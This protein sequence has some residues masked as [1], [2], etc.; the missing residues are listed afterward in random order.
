MS[1]C[2]D[3]SAM[4]AANVAPEGHVGVAGTAL[5]VADRL[6]ALRMR[7]DIGRMRYRVEPGLYSV[8]APGPDSP[9]LVTANYRLTFDHVRSN[10][11]GVDAWLLVVDTHGVNVWCAAGKGTFGTVQVCSAILGAGLDS[12][13]SHRTVILPQLGAPGVAAHDVKAFTGFR[14]VYGPVR[15]ADI[16][17]FLQAGSKATPAMRTVRFGLADRLVLTGVELST[18]WK[19]RTLV[20]L[21]AV[22]LLS[23]AG[24]WGYSVNALAARGGAAVLAAYLGL[25]AGALL[26]PAALPWLPFRS[27]AAKGATTGLLAAIAFYLFTASAI[28]PLAALGAS[29]ATVAISSYVAMNFTG[30]SPIT[31]FSGVDAEMRRALPF[32]VGAAVLAIVLWCVTAFVGKVW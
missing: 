17:A 11:A 30:S 12:I 25:L 26:M 23:G 1:G 14:V 5:S 16:T 31:S 3:T 4:P 6:G 21:A 27:F 18:G 24:A 8:G 20:W 28:G 13:V 19:P 10:L 2:C 22:A 9:V 32:Q 15:A 29:F 7:L